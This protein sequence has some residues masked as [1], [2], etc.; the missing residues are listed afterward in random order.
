MYTLRQYLFTLEDSLGLT[1]TLGEIELCRHADGCPIYVSGNRAIVFCIKHKERRFALRC[2]RAHHPYLRAIY[3]GQLLER[4]LYIYEE[5]RSGR[6]VDVVLTEWVEGEDFRI[7]IDH[8]ARNHDRT[9]LGLYAER[10]AGLAQELLKS[11][12]AH[13]DLKPENI[14]VTPD[15]ALRL[16]DFDATYTPQLQGCR[17]IESGTP[18]YQHP[19]RMGDSFGPHIDDFPAALITTALR[20]LWLDPTLYD[21]YGDRDGLLFV[22]HHLESDEAYA[23]AMALLAENGHALWY[24]IGASLRTPTPHIGT[25]RALFDALH[26]APRKP[27]GELELFAE[28]GL[29]GFRDEKGVAISPRYDN[30]FDFSEGLAAVQVG[31]RWHFIDEF[32]RVALRLPPCDIVKPMRDGRTEMR[33]GTER[34]TIDREGRILEN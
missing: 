16:I 33:R 7:A 26:E 24:R 22:P 28:R 11:E 10:F 17:P 12:Q 18:S 3:G 25:L 2:Y 23:E 29:W 9:L 4:E 32:G 6:W 13:G 20:A 30:G 1:R 15:G 14:I 19:L 8:A 27:V 34:L 5:N 31:P 21:R